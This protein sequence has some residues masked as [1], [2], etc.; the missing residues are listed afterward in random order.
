MSKTPTADEVKLRAAYDNVRAVLLEGDFQDRLEKPLAFWVLPADRRLPLA[1]LPRPLNELLQSSF[2][3]LAAASGIGKKKMLSLV[4][5]L[6]RALKTDPN[7]LSAFP[8]ERKSRPAAGAADN[9]Q[10]NPDLV[11]E[12]VWAQWREQVQVHGLAYEKVGRLCPAL[13][14]VPTV[15]WNTQLGFYLNYTLADI[16]ALKTHGEKRV[17]VV[18]EVFHAVHNMLT[19]T[20]SLGG[21]AVRLQPKFVIDL[22]NRLAAI[23]SHGTPP[24]RIQLEK[25]LIEPLLAQLE[26]DCG[27]TVA[28]IA[29]DRLG[30]GNE[31]VSVRVQARKL[32]VTR[33]R[34]YQL[35]EECN[36][37][38]VVRWPE[39]RRQ[40]DDF[41]A[42]LDEVYAPAECAN[43]LASLRELLFPPK[44]DALS[45]HMLHALPETAAAD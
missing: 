13:R 22:E 25:N 16:R 39:G 33:A 5:L 18:L 44:Y 41:A 31:G 28:A 36:R 45:D 20:H 19:T 38:M 8:G 35:L 37:V 11:S 32:G 2:D 14:D 40:L 1:F 3:E 17:R 26:L 10:F 6:G 29:R 24:T 7:A 15:I 42:W 4:K 9:G 43:L 27:D 21:L 30:I 12:L 23:R 34:V